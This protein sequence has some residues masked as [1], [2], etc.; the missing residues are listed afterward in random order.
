MSPSRQFPQKIHDFPP[1]L[2]TSLISRPQ[3]FLSETVND[4]NEREEKV[5]MWSEFWAN[6]GLLCRKLV[7]PSNSLAN[8]PQKNLK[9]NLRK[10]ASKWCA[11]TNPL[12]ELAVSV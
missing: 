7:A 5:K 1:I 10:M 8:Y 9:G 2:R 4:Y 6:G 11:N 12:H 3:D